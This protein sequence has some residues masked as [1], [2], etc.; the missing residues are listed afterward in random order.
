MTCYEEISWR[1]QWHVIAWTLASLI[2]TGCGHAVRNNAPSDA[3]MSTRIKLMTY[4]IHAW[5]DVSHQ[6]NFHRIVDVVKEI[7]PD[8][9]CVNE[10]LYPFA[11][12]S[13]SASTSSSSSLA[14]TVE[15][16]Y[17]QVRNGL[18][19]DYPLDPCFIPS[20][21]DQEL[22]FLH[23]LAE[24]TELP[25]V[26]FVGATDN[27][28]FGKG[29][30]FGNA[31]L[32]CHSILE[33][34]HI[35]LHPE[36]GDEALGKQPRDF[37]DP[38][39]L[40]AVKL[41]IVDTEH[42]DCIIGVVAGH[43]DH[44]SEEL[45]EKQIQRGI[46]ETN[47]FLRGIPHVV[48]GDFNTFRKSD[49]DVQGWQAILDLYKS[50][51]WPAPRENSLVLDSLDVSGHRDA[52]YDCYDDGEEPTYPQPTCWTNNPLMRIDHVFV[53]NPPQSK[54]ESSIIIPERHYRVETDASDHFPVVM[55]ASIATKRTSLI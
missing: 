36:D 43:L 16:Y 50:R 31:I 33:S 7:K 48:C 20:K 1:A 49:C 19:L 18:G 2:V 28:S 15:N 21:S 5:R 17:K 44:K 13:L 55:E 11:K 8:I 26:D 30:S 24:A 54:G 34:H 45:R 9:L 10:V 39:A 6:C 32:S 35:H 37:V 51:G 52:F 14:T 22:N 46:Q 27:S 3:T 12:P 41:K 38:R 29:V 23:R 4:N 47:D 25:S 40:T 53:K 42:Q